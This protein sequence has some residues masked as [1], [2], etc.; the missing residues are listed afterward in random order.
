MGAARKLRAVFFDMDDTILEPLPYN[1]WASFKERHGLPL[2]RLIL[3]GIATRPQ[4]QQTQLVKALIAYEFE[5]SQASSLREG[6]REVLDELS[7]RNLPTALLTNNHRRAT[8]T[9]L[10]K[11]QVEFSL[12]LTR[13]EAQPKPSPELLEKALQYFQLSPQQVAYVGDSKGDLE[14]CQ[15]LGVPIFFLS[16]PHNPE[17]SPRFE[18]PEELLEALLALG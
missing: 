4:A 11:H 15:Q 1:P 9:V 8:Q 16:T 3:D 17:F 12:V 18:Y 2:D 7:M 6:I 13:D 5:L 10:E 14:A